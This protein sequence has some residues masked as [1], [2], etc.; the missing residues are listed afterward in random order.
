MRWKLR[1]VGGGLLSNLR[2]GG[3]LNLA[4][5][6]L[7]NFT[8]GV[9]IGAAFASGESVGIAMGLS[10]LAHELPHEIG[11][12]AILVQNGCSPNPCASARSVAPDA[13]ALAEGRQPSTPSDS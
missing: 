8:D 4:A 7:H 11:D 5:D 2:A 13:A 3:F 1:T 10:V 12:F 9:G 6:S